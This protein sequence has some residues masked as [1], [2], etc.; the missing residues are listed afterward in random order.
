MKIRTDFVTNSSSSSFILGFKKAETI[1]N[2]LESDNH[3][4]YLETIFNDCKSAH[5][6]DLKTMLQ[7]IEED[8]EWQARF[9]LDEFDESDELQEEIS[10]RMKAIEDKAKERKNK[11]FVEVSYE[12]HY[13]D[14]A[15]LEQE[16]AP[17]L[18]CCLA[19]FNHH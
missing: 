8:V 19:S 18:N 16:V 10:R 6:M 9:A 5:K 13:H 14:G 17:Y 7:A 3:Q 2:E 12:D 1:L 11:V 15:I 4:G